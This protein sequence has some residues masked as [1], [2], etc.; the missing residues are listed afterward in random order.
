M[1]VHAATRSI[2]IIACLSSGSARFWRSPKKEE[3]YRHAYETV[4]E[5]KKGIATYVCYFNEERPHQGLDNLTLDD[6]YYR[7]KPLAKA[8]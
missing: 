1:S 5:A 6:V 8:A 3:A 7:R 2:A 4:A